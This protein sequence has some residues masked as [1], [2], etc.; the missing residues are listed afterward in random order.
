[1]SI[2]KSRSRLLTCWALALLLSPSLTIA[3]QAASS[4]EETVLKPIVVKGNRVR[5]GIT[6]LP[7]GP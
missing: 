7:R 5:R 1:M 2:Q 6:I 4:D 3:Q